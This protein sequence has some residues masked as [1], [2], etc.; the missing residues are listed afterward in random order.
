MLRFIKL[1]NYTHAALLD[2]ITRCIRNVSLYIHGGDNTLL[3]ADV[4]YR[5]HL[6]YEGRSKIGYILTVST[7][8]DSRI[9]FQVN[10]FSHAGRL[11]YVCVCVLQNSSCIYVPVSVN[12][13][14]SISYTCAAAIAKRISRHDGNFKYTQLLQKLHYTSSK[15]DPGG[16][17]GE[18]A[19]VYIYKKCAPEGLSD[20]ERI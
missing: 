9:T 6:V 3:S 19:N 4:Y 11:V 5:S 10:P 14:N 7:S 20:R 16:I 18:L 1:P 13:Y 12:C 17:F 8:H 2:R 15:L